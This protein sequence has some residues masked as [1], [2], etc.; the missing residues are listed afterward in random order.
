MPMPMERRESPSPRVDGNGLLI[1]LKIPDPATTHR[2]ETP[3]F[4]A[5]AP[6][7]IT[8]M[9]F[10]G[11]DEAPRLKK[12]SAAPQCKFYQTLQGCRFGKFCHFKHAGDLS[13]Q[14]APFMKSNKS[15]AYH[16][17]QRLASAR[18]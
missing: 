16:L 17:Q 14:L 13:Q 4:S 9:P 12:Q 1:R 7:L 8:P 6:N 5:L 18:G 10:P 2:E 11:P 15:L 3:P